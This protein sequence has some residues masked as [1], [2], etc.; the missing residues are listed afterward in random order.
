[1]ADQ[2]AEEQDNKF[3]EK[4]MVKYKQLKQKQKT[5]GRLH[6]TARTNE[7]LDEALNSE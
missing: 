7:I 6:E 3:A 4:K 2:L 5:D 1:M